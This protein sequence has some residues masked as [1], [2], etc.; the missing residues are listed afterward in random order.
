MGCS[1]A[2]HIT[3]FPW[4]ATRLLELRATGTVGDVIDHLHNERKPRLPDVIE[5]RERDLR[6]FYRTAGEDMPEIAAPFIAF[7][8]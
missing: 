4:L 1:Y 7:G 2:R 6:D 5:K 8:R 3:S